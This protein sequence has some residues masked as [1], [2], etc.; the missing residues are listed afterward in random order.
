MG[1]NPRGVGEGNGWM[2][3]REAIAGQGGLPRP[4]AA[5]AVSFAMR[6]DVAASMGSSQPQLLLHV[7]EPL[8]NRL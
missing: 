5:S 2:A 3:K 6:A 8:P 4:A 7:I 1:N